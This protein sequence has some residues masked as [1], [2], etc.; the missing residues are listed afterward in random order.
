MSGLAAV[1][2]NA[3]VTAVLQPVLTPVTQRWQQAVEK[4]MK[5]RRFLT[6]EISS[7]D[8]F[9]LADMVC[10]F[11]SECFCAKPVRPGTRSD[12]IPSLTAVLMKPP[13][14]GN[15][16]S[17]R[18][19]V[20]LRLAAPTM[21]AVSYSG[22]SFGLNPRTV[23]ADSLCQYSVMS[24]ESGEL[25]EKSMLISIFNQLTGSSNITGSGPVQDPGIVSHPNSY[26]ITI[27]ALSSPLI[28]SF[29]ACCVAFREQALAPFVEVRR[30]S[31][32]ILPSGWR[33]A[34]FLPKAVP[35]QQH[36]GVPA[37]EGN[38]G[39]ILAGEEADCV[40]PVAE[41]IGPHAPEAYEMEVYRAQSW[42]EKHIFP[43]RI[44]EDMQSFFSPETQLLYQRIGV[45]Y[46]RCYLFYGPPGCGKTMMC[47]EAARVL[48]VPL[49][50]LDCRANAPE[51]EAA[52][53]SVRGPGIV[54]IEEAE[55][56][57]QEQVGDAGYLGTILTLLDGVFTAEKIVFV[58]TTNEPTRLLRD[59]RLSR[60]GRIDKL[61]YFGYCSWR[62]FGVALLRADLGLLLDH[63]RGRGP[64]DYL[65]MLLLQNP[66]PVVTVLTK[67]LSWRNRLD[68]RLADRDRLLDTFCDEALAFLARQ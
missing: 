43:A 39:P 56:Y 26:L 38:T 30:F 63:L 59:G 41:D 60:D 57:L 11:L 2:L 37:E 32:N 25:T 67:V 35:M 10:G 52:L 22:S 14:M 66:R 27:C 24:G 7:S 4:W 45:R 28:E 8:N 50:Y 49:Y 62:M 55:R 61:V 9:E 6:V 48:G 15:T 42:M 40:F 12:A 16:Q 46:H 31:S 51:T 53:S 29:L 1:A 23:S 13:D 34:K 68:N 18:S 33:P 21:L 64:E 54:V 58:F 65:R 5:G 17:E 3:G 19:T 47:A 36:A 20:S 44:I